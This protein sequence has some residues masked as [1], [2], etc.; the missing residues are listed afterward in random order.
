M[1]DEITRFV[2]DEGSPSV[3]MYIAK[4]KLIIATQ[5]KFEP[6]MLM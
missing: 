4:S 1:N 3:R 2:K 5:L 6:G